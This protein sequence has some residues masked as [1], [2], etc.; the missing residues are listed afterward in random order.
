M[1]RAQELEGVPPFRRQANYTAYIEGWGLYTESLGSELGFYTDPYS[2]FGQLSNELWRAA[3]LV[4]DTGIHAFGW[5][6]D[7]AIEYLRANS[8]RT[9][10]DILVEVDRYIDAPGRS[11]AYKS[12]E[13]VIKQLRRHAEHTLGRRF[14]I[15]AVHDELLGQGA[16]PLDVLDAHMRRWVAKQRAAR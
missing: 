8:A 6:R 7:E 16:L 13:L 12:G 5:T 14:D 10:P 1:A 11:L 15:R 9:E 4:L 3:R 2:K